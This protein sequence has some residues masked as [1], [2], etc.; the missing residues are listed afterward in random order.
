MPVDATFIQSVTDAFKS[1]HSILALSRSPLAVGALIAPAL[2]LDDVSPTPDERGQA[3]RLALQWAVEQ[4]APEPTSQPIGA[5]R[6]LDDPTWRDPRWW[7]YTLLRHRY[8]EPLH[9]DEFVE[10][11]RFT[12]T[13]LALTG[14]PTADIL[15]DER[16][17]A[18]REA[19]Q[20]LHR[21][22]TSEIANE[23]L[24]QMALE[25]V[26]RPLAGKASAL[27]L[28]GIAAIFNDV[29][30]RKLLLDLAAQERLTRVDAALDELLAERYLL[31]GDGASNLWMSPVLRSFIYDRQPVPE[32][33]RRHLFAARHF[34][35]L[36]AGLA[37]VRHWQLAGEW[38]QATDDL[39]RC[40]LDPNLDAQPVQ[41][42]ALL[43]AFKSNTVNV[44]QWRDLQILLSDML[45]RS[46]Q[47]EEALNACREALKSTSDPAQQARIYRRIGKLYE[48]QNQQHAFSYYQLAS[49]RFAPN[50]PEYA[51]LLKD[52][53]WLRVLRREWEHAEA[54]LTLALSIVVP[55]ALELRADVLDALSSLQRGRGQA[56]QAIESAQS[57]LA[58]REQAGDP[59]GVAKS[60]NTL[61]ILYRTLAEYGNAIAAYNEAIAIYQRLDNTALI[62]TALLNIGAAHHFAGDLHEAERHYQRCLNLC[63][64]TGGLVLTEVRAHSNLCEVLMDLQQVEAARLHW[65]SGCSLSVQSGFDDE[66]AYFRDLCQ[67]YPALQSEL[68]Q[69]D[70]LTSQPKDT[71]PPASDQATAPLAVRSTPEQNGADLPLQGLNADDRQVLILAQSAGRV[72]ARNLMEA[73]HVSKATATRRLAA[74]AERGLLQRHGEGRGVHY[75]LNSKP[76]VAPVSVA[77]E[78]SAVIDYT[79]SL[80]AA[81]PQ[82]APPVSI[83]S[84]HAPRLY[85][86][87]DSGELRLDVHVHVDKQLDLTSFFDLERRI[88][89]LIG[90]EVNLLVDIQSRISNLESLVDI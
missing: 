6:P 87:V 56:R 67:R 5:A 85:R 48:E 44:E 76:I 77:A 47:P 25:S 66:V 40:A 57:A 49:E 45:V 62:A 41:F 74:L 11:G 22:L 27:A 50:D 75:V 81:L 71:P 33:R 20:W 1:C 36:G 18:I 82:L 53:G 8:L 52:R 84:M 72:S 69:I 63:Q 4:L 55:D 30:S 43:R 46:S 60:F 10:G 51:I 39:L 16:N 89:R 88:G 80:M 17:R 83:S 13:L 54:D 24:R 15:F 19:G 9:P 32:L 2:V 26:Y 37:V 78:Q 34:R 29:F 42:I 90:V 38:R 3:L 7:R 73:G 12:E 23:R 58:L 14:I 65:R 68:A 35:Q 28:L 59:L 70:R 61:G 64:E 86:A 79:E 31:A 21:Q